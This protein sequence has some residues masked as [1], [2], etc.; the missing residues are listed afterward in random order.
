MFE[1]EISLFFVA[2]IIYEYYEQKNHT[3]REK[4]NLTY[5]SSWRQANNEASVG[6]S[7]VAEKGHPSD[8]DNLSKCINSLLVH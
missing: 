4:T 2:F 1:Y 8:R 7:E 3:Y 5:V 6:Y